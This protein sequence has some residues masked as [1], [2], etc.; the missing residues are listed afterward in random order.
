M[1]NRNAPSGLDLLRNSVENFDRLRLLLEVNTYLSNFE[2]DKCLQ[3]LK[4]DPK[5][6]QDYILNND[7]N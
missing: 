7:Y 2:G 4:T 5:F 6:I 3:L 1:G